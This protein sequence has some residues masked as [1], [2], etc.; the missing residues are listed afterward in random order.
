MTLSVYIVNFVILMENT[1]ILSLQ[2]NLQLTPR[3]GPFIIVC[4]SSL[5]RKYIAFLLLTFVYHVS[6][7]VCLMIV[8]VFISLFSPRLNYRLCWCRIWNDIFSGDFS[9]WRKCLFIIIFWSVVIRFIRNWLIFIL[10]YGFILVFLSC[11]VLA[12]FWCLPVCGSCFFRILFLLIS[13]WLKCSLLPRSFFN[14]PVLFDVVT[15]S[16]SWHVWLLVSFR[17]K[18]C[19]N[20]SFLAPPAEWQ[21][22]FY[23]AELSV[24]VRQRFT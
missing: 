12:K 19:D 5:L 22:S 20:S 21:R 11:L 18:L 9:L 15:S 23:N 3:H 8:I 7:L 6:T 2:L 24:V 4:I 13:L 10:L 1:C 16:L 17:F 14:G